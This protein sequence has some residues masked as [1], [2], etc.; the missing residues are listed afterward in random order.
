ML[1]CTCPDE[2]VRRRLEER[3]EKRD[4]PSDATWEIFRE[5]K[6][7][8]EPIEPDERAYCRRWDSTTDHN[9]FL[10]DVVRELMIPR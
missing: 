8:F 7:R 2:I 4:E 3:R 9:T 1:E 5:Q 10:K 6:K